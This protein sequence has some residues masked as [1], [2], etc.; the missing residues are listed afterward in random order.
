MFQGWT[1][2]SA[3]FL[4]ASTLARSQA[5]AP[6]PPGYSAIPRQSAGER[7]E[8]LFPTSSQALPELE[9]WDRVRNSACAWRERTRGP[10]PATET[11]RQG[12]P[13]HAGAGRGPHT[14]AAVRAA[15]TSRSGSHVLRSPFRLRR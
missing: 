8:T 13:Q 6:H 2:L 14:W 7:P 10:L 5:T 3:R 15:V 1:L 4:Q 11:P 12:R 9:I